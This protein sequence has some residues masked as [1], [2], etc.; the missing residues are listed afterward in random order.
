MEQQH[1]FDKPKNVRRLLWLLYLSCALLLAA[2]LF[3][4]RH[5]AHDWESLWGFY[6]FFGFV[7]CVSLVLVA[8]QLRKLLKR[9]EDYYDR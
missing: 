3:I 4:H 1:L 7:A 5:V 8:R 2:D 6:A 9:P